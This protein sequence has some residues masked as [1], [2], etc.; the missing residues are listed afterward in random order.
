MIV[1]RSPPGPK[2]VG[3]TREAKVLCFSASTSQAV[4]KCDRRVIVLASSSA[5]FYLSLLAMIACLIASL[6][7]TAS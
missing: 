3:T 7:S 2:C 4:S 5:W 1:I 6:P